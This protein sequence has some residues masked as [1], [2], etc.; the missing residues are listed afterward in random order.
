VPGGSAED[1][2]NRAGAAEKPRGRQDTADVGISVGRLVPM[3]GADVVDIV[4]TIPARR[5]SARVVSGL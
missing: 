2:M 5:N 3:A 4:H 1:C